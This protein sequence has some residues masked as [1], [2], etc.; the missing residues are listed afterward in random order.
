MPIDWRRRAKAAR[1][2]HGGPIR[3]ISLAPVAGVMLVLAA[4][5]SLS[6]PAPTHAINF[7]LPPLFNSGDYT[8]IETDIRVDRI[9]IDREGQTFWNNTP[10]NHA[11]LRELL[12]A[13]WKEPVA[14]NLIFEPDDDA[15]YGAAL[16]VLG[17]IKQSGVWK[18]CFGGLHR[19][20]R[21]ELLAS[22]PS[23]PAIT[24]QE[25]EAAFSIPPHLVDY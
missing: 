18:F 15:A 12:E 6:Y 16:P 11:Q 4:M 24:Q 22:I 3:Y 17:V 7:E 21:F 1:F 2:D 5:V 20:R 25:C 13:T 9:S 23:D 8:T 10:V 19:H 14:P